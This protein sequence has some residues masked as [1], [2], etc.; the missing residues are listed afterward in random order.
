MRVPLLCAATTAALVLGLGLP[1]TAAELGGSGSEPSAAHSAAPRESQ[2]SDSHASELAS[3]EAA[4]TKG[5]RTPLATTEAKAP[6][7]RAKS[8]TAPT[9]TARAVKIDAKISA[10]AARAKLGAAKGATASVKGGVRQNYARGAVFL[11]KG[12]K[13]AYAVRSGMLGRYRSA[14]GLPTG[15][16]AC[17]GK[18]WCTQPFSGSPRTLSWTSGKMRVCTGLRKRVEGKKASALQVIEVDQTSTRHANV[19]ACV[20]DSNG[21]YKRDGGA[22]A[23]LVG[24]T[25]TATKKREGDGKTPRGVYWMRGGFGTSKNPG[26][27][28][29]R[30]TKV[31][32]KTVWVDSSASKYYNTMRPSG[33]SE[34]L[35]QRGP[36]RHAQVIGYNEKRAKGKGSAIFLHR[37]TSA[38]NYTMGC[39]AVYDSSLVKLMKWQISKDVQIAI[40]A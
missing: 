8:A 20:R 26:L 30:Y 39:V 6:T 18:N 2:A 1:A 29:Q 12:A 21:T 15:N 14:A 4:Q 34:K 17:H 32:K 35:Y 37:R 36:Y 11:K 28:H 16:E 10:A 40:H 9:A 13:T 33:K 24:K 27:K 3:S 25:G 7:A 23:G 19:Y 22:Y 5:A 38:S 31:T